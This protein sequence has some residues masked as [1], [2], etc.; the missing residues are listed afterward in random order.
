MVSLLAAAG[1]FLAAC[2]SS[3]GSSGAGDP[4]NPSGE[5]TGYTFEDAGTEVAI[6][7]KAEPVIDALGE[8]LSS[9]EAESCAFG[10]LD[11]TWTYN[12]YTINTYQTDEVDYIYD[13]LLTS[14]SVSTPEGVSI[15]DSVDAVKEAYGDPEEEDEAQLVYRKGDMRLIFLVDGGSVTSIDYQSSMLEK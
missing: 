4:A 3:A 12:G 8:P 15:G 10:D 13:I 9:F 11:K 7:V 5:A 6:G 1:I 2:G 14:D